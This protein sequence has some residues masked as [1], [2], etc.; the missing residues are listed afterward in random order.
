MARYEQPKPERLNIELHDIRGNV[1]NI[2]LL[3]SKIARFAM[4]DV[5]QI[6]VTQTICENWCA[7]KTYKITSTKKVSFTRNEVCCAFC[8]GLRGV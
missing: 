7:W 6:H 4:L 3:R 1:E 8:E 2:D 5:K